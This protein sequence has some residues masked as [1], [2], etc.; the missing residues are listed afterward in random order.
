MGDIVG[1]RA[2]QA[3]GTAPPGRRDRDRR[4]PADSAHRPRARSPGADRDDGVLRRPRRHAD[5]RADTS[6]SPRQAPTTSSQAPATGWCSPA[7]RTT[8]GTGPESPSRSSYSFGVTLC[9]RGHRRSRAGHSDYL[10]AEAFRRSNPGP[11]ALLQALERRYG[12]ASAAARSGHQRYFVDPCAGHGLLHLQHRAR[13]VFAS[14]PLRRAVNYAIDRRALVQHH[15]PF[16]GERATDHYLPPGMPGRG[17]VDIISARRPDLAKARAA[18]AGVHAHATMYYAMRGTP[19]C[20]GGR[21]GSS[22]PTS[23]RSAYARDHPAPGCRALQPPGTAR[24]AVGHRLYELGRRLRRPGRHDQHAV[25]P[26]LRR[27]RGLRALQ[28]PRPHQA[29]APSSHAQRRSPATGLRPPRRGPQPETT[30]PAAAWGNGT[31]RDFF[32]ARSAARSTS[33]STGIDLGGR[34]PPTM[35]ATTTTSSHTSRPQTRAPKHLNRARR[36]RHSIDHSMPNLCLCTRRG[37][38]ARTT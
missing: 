30:H 9:H 18:G 6:R 36:H 33:R 27:R 22:R 10:D 35:S 17:P 4:S 13:P 23:P 37:R 21:R 24:R 3:G 11:L 5:D 31:V 2:Y 38:W 19:H 15:F 7:T 28:R 16:N 29:H 1:M 20:G 32:S 12:P 25:R 34:L 26:R 8:A 14:A